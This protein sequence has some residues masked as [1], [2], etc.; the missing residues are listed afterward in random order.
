MSVEPVRES[1]EESEDGEVK[2]GRGW[3]ILP[4]PET[5][6]P[7]EAVWCVSQLKVVGLHNYLAAQVEGK[8]AS[9]FTRRQG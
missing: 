1:E 7:A 8:K 3:S 6:A 2:G 5:D 4:E 9:A